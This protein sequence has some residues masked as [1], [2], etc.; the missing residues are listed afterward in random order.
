MLAG[1][2][3]LGENTMGEVAAKEEEAEQ[4]QTGA[5]PYPHYNPCTHSRRSV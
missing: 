1:G 4:Q 5:Y 2:D 3:L